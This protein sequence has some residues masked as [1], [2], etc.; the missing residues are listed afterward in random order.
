MAGLDLGHG[1]FG[2][3]LKGCVPQC[4]TLVRDKCPAMSRPVPV[5]RSIGG[6]AKGFVNLDITGIG[7]FLTPQPLRQNRYVMGQLIH[8]RL[9]AREKE[10]VNSGVLD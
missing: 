4:P 3:P 10:Q 2:T 9:E 1:T 8:N 5:S 6:G 7:L